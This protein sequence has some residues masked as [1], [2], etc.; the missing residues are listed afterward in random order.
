MSR[1]LSHP[2]KSKLVADDM[3]VNCPKFL[4]NLK[5]LKMLHIYYFQENKAFMARIIFTVAS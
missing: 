4:K 5:N 1:L 2:K 3:R